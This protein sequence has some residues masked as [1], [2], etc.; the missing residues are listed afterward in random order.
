M[1]ILLAITGGISAYKAVDIVSGLK[2]ND[3]FVSVM[4]TPNSLNFVTEATIRNTANKYYGWKIDWG[5][6][7]HIL[8]SEPENNIDVF[9]VV[10]ATANTIAKMANGIADNLVTDTYLAIPNNVLKIVCPAMNTRML[11][12]PT[13]KRN[14]DILRDDNVIIIQPMEGLLACGTVGKGKLMTTKSLVELIIS[15]IK[16]KPKGKL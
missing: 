9:I 6:P 3:C 11:N 4:Q 14:L 12:H 7:L 2:K 13:V 5:T 10:P 16:S 1:N 8:A 15:V